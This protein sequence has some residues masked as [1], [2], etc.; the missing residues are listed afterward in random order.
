MKLRRVS[1]GPILVAAL[2]LLGCANAAP[3]SIPTLTPVPSNSQTPN[4]LMQKL[5]K[6]LTRRV[7][8][9]DFAGV[10][11]VA[12]GGT[13]LL[14]KGYGFADSAKKIPNTTDTRF[15]LASVS[16][17]LTATAVMTLVER[18][19]LDLQAPVSKYLADTPKIWQSITLQELLS[20][21]SGIPDYFT[22]DEF[23]GVFDLTPDGIIAV[24]K[25]YPL[26][27]DPGTD[28]EYSNTGFVILGK[29]IEN[30]T[31]MSY[32]AYMRQ[33]IFDPLQMKATGRDENNI[34]LAVG[35]AS[36]GR[37]AKIYPI[38]NELGD[39]DF[40]STVDD[41]Y[42]FDR[43]LYGETI[44]SK[45]VRERMFTSIG[46]NNYGLGWEVDTWKGKRVVSH[47]G[48]LNGFATEFMRFPDEDAVII[49]LSN[50]ENFDATQAAWALAKIVFS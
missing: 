42:R 20:H 11:L 18:G 4:A 28:Y 45:S 2:I 32:G 7:K 30:V 49:I 1:L 47:S 12:Q 39:G 16:K 15:Q 44:V 22:F 46:D 14:E 33:T 19:K 21:T 35:Y 5:D 24:A 41:M 27:F 26:S 43:A 40:L 25:K 31:G 23:N 50:L 10:V 48:G 29:I 6:Y 9:D 3:T 13:I 37:R 38:T 17:T 34:P 36:H 8:S